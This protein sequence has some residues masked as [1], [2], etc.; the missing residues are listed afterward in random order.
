MTR[1][2]LSST[3]PVGVLTPYTVFALTLGF[4][5]FLLAPLVPSIS[6]A[7][8]VAIPVV[9]VFISLYGYAMVVGSLPAGYWVA[10]R[11]PRPALGAAIL[12]TVVGLLIRALAPNLALFWVGQSVA[13]LAYPCL[14]APIGSVLRLSGVKHLKAGTGLTIG[15]LFLGM[16]LGALLGPALG[17]QGGFWVS[18]VA[19]LAAG[20]WLWRELGKL[21]AHTA[22]DLGPVKLV[23]SAWWIV[24]FVVAS[25]SVMMGAIAVPV[26]LHLKVAS[27]LPLGGLLTALT[28]LG[29]AVGAAGFGRYGEMLPNTAQIQRVL[30]VLTLL[31]VLGVSLVMTGALPAASAVPLVLFFLMGAFGNG[32]YSLALEAAAEAARSAGSAGLATAGYSMASNVGVA[33]VPAILGPLALGAPGVWLTVTMVLALVAAAIPFLVKATARPEAQR[34]AV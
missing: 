25:T 24:G 23:V 2:A 21:P 12:L 18:V 8:G 3:A 1:T 29:S 20:V 11:G 33:L 9:L 7:L 5:W 16:A 19:N 26:L 32:W 30:G 31:A 4:S 17:L 22:M 13:A 15:M 14:I 34:I 27:A 10:R 28:F 6:S